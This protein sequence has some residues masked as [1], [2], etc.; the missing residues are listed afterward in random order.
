MAQR[1]YKSKQ[2]PSSVEPIDPEDG[3]YVV[4]K[5]NEVITEIATKLADDFVSFEE[6]PAIVIPVVPKYNKGIS[7]IIQIRS[8]VDA[9]YKTVGAV[10]G[11]VYIFYGGGSVVDVNKEDVDELL[12]RRKGK[13]CAGCSGIDTPNSAF[14][15]V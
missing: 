7:N 1:T 13:G 5:S 15:L 3:S 6:K 14:E 4:D 11:R 12:S 8:K 10:S 2:Y 9:T